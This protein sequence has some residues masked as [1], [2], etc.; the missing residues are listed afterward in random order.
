MYFSHAAPFGAYDGIGQTYH[1]AY[2]Y[3][4]G[5]GFVH[6]AWNGFTKSCH[7]RMFETLREFV[8]WHYKCLGWQ[9]LENGYPLEAEVQSL[10]FIESN[11]INN[12]TQFLHSISDS[13]NQPPLPPNPPPT[14]PQ[15][16]PPRKA[17]S[18]GIRP[19]SPEALGEKSDK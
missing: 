16:P 5:Q 6:S 8:I 2:I 12:A 10:S 17:R 15:V 13:E 1:H 7:I 19:P 11:H 3:W 9:V 4:N 14:P 18:K